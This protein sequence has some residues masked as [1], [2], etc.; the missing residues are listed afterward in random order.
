MLVAVLAERST[1]VHV[2]SDQFV[3]GENMR[4]YVS[5]IDGS[6]TRDA[7]KEVVTCIDNE[8]VLIQKGVGNSIC[9]WR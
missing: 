6:V 8:G 7:D 4:P 9:E 5:K 3:V 1:K 2:W